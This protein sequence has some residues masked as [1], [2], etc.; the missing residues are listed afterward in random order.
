MNVCAWC[1]QTIETVRGYLS[2]RRKRNFG[3][4]F[5]R[6][7]AHLAAL[8]D[9]MGKR[10]VARARRMRKCGKSLPH[11]QQVLGVSQSTIRA[12]LRAA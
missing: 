3:M 10:E 4:C 1:G 11:I 2:G 9:L 12:A 8:P 7:H 6:L 5:R